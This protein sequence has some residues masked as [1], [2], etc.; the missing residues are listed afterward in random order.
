MQS[1]CIAPYGYGGLGGAFGD[2]S[3]FTQHLGAGVEL[4]L[5][6]RVGVFADYSYNFGDETTDWNL[7]T[8]GMRL[9]F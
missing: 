8:V 4:R 6:G 9:L 5:T 7:Y 3:Q 1:L 2:E